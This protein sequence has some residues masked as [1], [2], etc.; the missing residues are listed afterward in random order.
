MLAAGHANYRDTKPVARHGEISPEVQHGTGLGGMPLP[1][2]CLPA[3]IVKAGSA[4]NIQSTIGDHPIS[5]FLCL[6]LLCSP[7]IAKENTL[8]VPGKSVGPITARSTR[9][10]LVQFFGAAN[11]K[12]AS[13]YPGEG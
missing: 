10:D 9:A 8:L 3:C 4:C 13:I 2:L 7:V 5:L 1:V 11:V 6:L 12:A